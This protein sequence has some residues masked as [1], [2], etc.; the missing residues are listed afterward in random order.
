MI[1]NGT[2]N[3]DRTLNMETAHRLGWDKQLEERARPAPQ[4]P[5]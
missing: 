2:L 5:E 1:Q 3:P 4:P